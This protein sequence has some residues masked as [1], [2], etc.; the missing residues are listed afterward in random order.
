MLGLAIYFTPPTLL[1][2]GWKWALLACIS[3]PFA[4]LAKAV[5]EGIFELAFI[6]YVKVLFLVLSFGHVRPERESEFVDF[7]WFQVGKGSD[8]K[9]VVGEDVAALFAVLVAVGAGF[10]LY[11]L[12]E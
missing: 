7:P 11:Y 10:S 3:L 1:S 5:L 9:W 4:L 2:E 6:G 8:G 12:L